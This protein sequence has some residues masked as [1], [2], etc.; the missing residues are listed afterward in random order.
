MGITEQ[1]DLEENSCVHVLWNGV[2]HGTPLPHTYI[3]YLHL[4]V[5]FLN[6]SAEL[7]DWYSIPPSGGGNVKFYSE[8]LLL[9]GSVAFL[10]IFA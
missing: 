8:S 3:Y 1:L 4:R 2:Y 9:H 7:L 10:S 6:N 5:E